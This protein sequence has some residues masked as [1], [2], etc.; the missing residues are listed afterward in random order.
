MIEDEGDQP[1][2]QPRMQ[3]NTCRVRT[4][5]AEMDDLFK[6]L[7]EHIVSRNNVERKVTEQ[8]AIIKALTTSVKQL[9]TKLNAFQDRIKL[10]EKASEEV[11][12]IAL[13]QTRPQWVRV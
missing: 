4:L 13:V 6:L 3:G 9:E 12:W 7:T 2:S 10:L 8:Y 1:P 11:L 5:T